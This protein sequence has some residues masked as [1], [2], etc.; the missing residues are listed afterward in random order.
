MGLF[1]GL[2][3]CLSSIV[4]GL[5]LLGS[6]YAGWRWGDAIF[7]RLENEVAEWRAEADR[8]SL[9]S[10]AVADAA[11][12]RYE[13]FRTT[14]GPGEVL[15]DS[16]ELTSLVR[17]RA[18]ERLPRGVDEVEV[19]MSEGRLDVRMD[20][21]RDQIPDFPDLRELDALVS[22]TVTVRMVGTVIP[23]RG[24]GAAVL[25]DRLEV[26]RLPLPRRVVPTVLSALGREPA[27]GLPEEAIE[28][29][30]PPGIT[31]AYVDGDHL[32]LTGAR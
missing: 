12:D 9:A 13:R 28:I 8:P 30:L 11:W 3:G 14:G 10:P 19:E 16:A 21:A 15:F 23:S 6:A 22:D 29:P 4:T 24:T 5:L 27:P 17:Y 20:I 26:A 2:R 1:R 25:I 18:L 31:S 32:V 7:P